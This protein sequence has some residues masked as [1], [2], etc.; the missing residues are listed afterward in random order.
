MDKFTEIHLFGLPNF[1]EIQSHKIELDL[2]DH[3][4][5]QQMK[6]QAETIATKLKHQFHARKAIV[7]RIIAGNIIVYDR[8][9]EN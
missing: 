5:V 8:N 9:T 1:K 6:V 4:T 2:P 3:A 7:G